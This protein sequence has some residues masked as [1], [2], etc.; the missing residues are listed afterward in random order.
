MTT[1][2]EDTYYDTIR[3]DEELYNLTSKF[4]INDKI[5]YKIDD[6][7]NIIK[8]T[9]VEFVQDTS[10]WIYNRRIDLEKIK[11]LKE[12]IQVFD[13]NSSPVWNISLIYD[14]LSHKNILLYVID[15]QHRR[16]VVRELLKEGKINEDFEII[17]TTYNINHCQTIN[18]NVATE[19]FK[20]INNNLPLDLN[21]IPDTFVQDIIEKIINDN[22]LNPS[23]KGIKIQITNGDDSTAHEP[24]I[25]KQ[26]LFRL[27]NDNIESFKNLSIDEIVSNLRLI[28][29]KICYNPSEDIYVKTERHNDKYHMAKSIN[30]WLGL[31]SSK[32]YSPNEWIKYITKPHDFK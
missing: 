12:Q 19:L 31:K 11:E 26:Q 22:E 29:K 24:R 5:I 3:D 14:E 27:F 30:F 2:E 21:D 13:K 8:I 4:N 18:K 10:I 17:C 15:G 9:A 25:H 23:K 20:K 6:F 1:F 16:E 28:K 7:K 32:K